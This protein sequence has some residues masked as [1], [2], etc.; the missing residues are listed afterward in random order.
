MAVMILG[1]TDGEVEDL[2]TNGSYPTMS[3]D[4][5]PEFQYS[6]LHQFCLGIYLKSIILGA[7]IVAMRPMTCRVIV[8]A[9]ATSMNSS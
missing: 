1:T 6:I 2:D 3:T 4:K 9:L 7:G 8:L 5:I